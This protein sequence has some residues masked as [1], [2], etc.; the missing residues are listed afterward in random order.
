MRILG[1]FTGK[2]RGHKVHNSWISAVSDNT[3]SFIPKP[4]YRLYDYM[5]RKPFLCTLSPL[6]HQPL[7][8]IKGLFM[9]PVEI[10]LIEGTEAMP[11]L[12]FKKGKIV[13][14][15][16]GPFFPF[17]KEYKGLKKLYAK[18]IVKRID[19]IISSTY[20]MRKYS[21][22]Y[23]KVPNEVVYLYVDVGKYGKVKPHLHSQDVCCVA[24]PTFSKGTDI[25]V[26]AFKIYR[27]EFPDAKLYLC[28]EIFKGSWGCC[29]RSL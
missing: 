20:M 22:K 13:L 18:W 5:Q 21:E 3:T 15:N 7:S 25:L 29:S 28:G 27:R 9:K 4:F 2:F 1:I 19:G 11:A 16:D 8:F 12:F 26:D 10:Y 14:I 24:K 17:F 6:I 23:T